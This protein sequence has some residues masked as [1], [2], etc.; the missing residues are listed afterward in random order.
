MPVD[1]QWVVV[2]NLDTILINSKQKHLLK[3]CCCCGGGPPPILPPI[4]GSGCGGCNGGGPI[5]VNCEGRGG[6]F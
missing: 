6:I 4:G 1:S 2:V 3:G 5:I